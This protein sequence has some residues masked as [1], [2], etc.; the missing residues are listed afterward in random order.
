MPA[1]SRKSVR[2]YRRGSPHRAAKRADGMREIR[3]WVPNAARPGFAADLRRQSTRIAR[4]QEESEIDAW[5][6]AVRDTRGWTY[7]A[8]T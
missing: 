7:G 6:D 5:L 8:G 2:R 1:T 4:A 3:V